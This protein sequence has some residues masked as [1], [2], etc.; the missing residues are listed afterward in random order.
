MKKL[1]LPVA[2]VVVTV[3]AMLQSCTSPQKSVGPN[4]L[5]ESE[6]ADGWQLL[7]NGSDLDGW[8]RFNNDTIGPLWTVQ[9]G[10]IVCDGTGLG[11]GSGKY[12]GSLM[13]TRQFGNFELSVD[14]M[15]T[16]PGGN[17]GI[18]YHT[19][20]GSEYG[21]DYYTGPEMQVID[22]D[23][24]QGDLTPAQKVGS[25]YDMFAASETKKVNPVGQWNT[26][27]IIYKD[28]HVEHWLNG[29]KVVEF[30][31]GSPEFEEAYKKSKWVEFPAWNTFKVGSISL[32]DHG[33]PVKFRN[34]KIREI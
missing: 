27:K 7:F 26:A 3:G 13:T 31:E 10:A 32:Q 33:A 14:W 1:L 30:E 2:L 17:S 21:A 29:E 11:E 18:I 34:I 5:T 12:G 23:G 9:D 19:V 4:Q 16:T 25:N 8:K 6:I 24:W 22:D 28:G 15:I 20:E